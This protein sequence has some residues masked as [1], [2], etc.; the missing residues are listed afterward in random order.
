MNLTYLIINYQ[1]SQQEI[2]IK[3][4]ITKINCVK[5]DSH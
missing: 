1:N 3:T 2:Q 4:N 5:L